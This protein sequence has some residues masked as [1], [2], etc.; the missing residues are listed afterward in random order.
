MASSSSGRCADPMVRPPFPFGGK[1]GPFIQ[2]TQHTFPSALHAWDCTSADSDLHIADT[3]A[4]M[5]PASAM[6]S[7]RRER[8]AGRSPLA[9]ITCSMQDSIPDHARARRRASRCRL[10]P[11]GARPGASGGELGRGSREAQSFFVTATPTRPADS[12]P[13]RTSSRTPRRRRRGG[14][15]RRPA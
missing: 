1:P 2:V 4:S 15:R 9:A 7:V 12:G 14:L 10:P 13:G 8:A 3:T 5:P 6:P 11:A